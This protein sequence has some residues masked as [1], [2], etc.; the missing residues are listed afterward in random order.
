MN[1]TSSKYNYTR[2]QTQQYS[3]PKKQEY[4]HSGYGRI[5]RAVSSRTSSAL[6]DYPSYNLNTEG[7]RNDVKSKLMVDTSDIDRK[8][9]EI[10]QKYQEYAGQS[11]NYR[12]Y[13]IA[14][15]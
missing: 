1:R 15:P 2:K 7:S 12:K 13:N 6:D 10:R 8:I 11:V 4:E 5:K 3:P 14:E 9:N